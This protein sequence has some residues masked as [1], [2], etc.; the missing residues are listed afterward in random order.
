MWKV[1]YIASNK[2]KADRMKERLTEEGFLV[3]VK[4]MGVNAYDGYQLLVPQ[5]EAVEVAEFL[6]QSYQF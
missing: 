6:S 4:P 1:V 5:S 2:E 3:K